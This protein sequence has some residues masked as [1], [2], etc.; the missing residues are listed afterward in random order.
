[1]YCWTIKHLFMRWI[2][3]RSGRQAASSRAPVGGLGME[4]SCGTKLPLP[5]SIELARACSVVPCCASAS[6][7][8]TDPNRSQP[9]QVAWQVPSSFE[10]PRDGN[11]EVVLSSV[12]T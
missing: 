12:N 10:S 7:T 5:S 9:W 2:G 11:C 6:L 8:T 1:M 3:R 4:L